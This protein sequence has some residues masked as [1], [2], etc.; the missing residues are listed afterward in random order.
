MNRFKILVTKTIIMSLLICLIFDKKTYALDQPTLNV[1]IELK[2]QFK[3]SNMVVVPIPV[4]TIID[5]LRLDPNPE[6]SSQVKLNK[7]IARSLDTVNIKVADCSEEIAKHIDEDLYFKSDSHWQSRG[8]YYAYKKFCEV[9]GEECPPIDSYRRVVLNDKYVGDLYKNT[10]RK[11]NP[12]V[13]DELVV[14]ISSISNIMTIYN[15][16]NVKTITGLPCI[17]E[18]KKSYFGIYMGGSG[19]YTEIEAFNDKTKTALVIKDSFGF[20]FVPYLVSNYDIIYVMDARFVDFKLKEKM[21]NIRIDDLIV[22]N[23]NYGLNKNAFTKH[24]NKLLDDE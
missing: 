6:N 13:S 12:N 24:M 8:A 18:Y 16:N 19:Y 1:L 3:D 5:D 7:S 9:I 15:N 14:Y 17:N 2:N 23:A 20:P 10:N 21:K 4:S 22:V 11:V